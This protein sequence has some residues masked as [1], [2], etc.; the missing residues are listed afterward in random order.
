MYDVHIGTSI[1]IRFHL[2][3]KDAAFFLSLL[4]SLV[5]NEIYRVIIE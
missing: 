4:T 2:F 3:I 1:S 5:K